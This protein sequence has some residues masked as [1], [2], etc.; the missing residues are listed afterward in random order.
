MLEWIQN[1]IQNILIAIG[2]AVVL[3]WPKIK[4]QL[5][6]SQNGGGKHQRTKDTSTAIA[7][8]PKNLTMTIQIS[9]SGLSAQWKPEPTAWI[10]N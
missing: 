7:V 8:V 4:E 5:A 2:A 6:A 1:N 10:T 3:F 9:P